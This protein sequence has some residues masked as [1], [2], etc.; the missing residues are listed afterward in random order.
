MLTTTPHLNHNAIQEND[1]RRSVYILHTENSRVLRLAWRT[2]GEE[3]EEVVLR[4][5]GILCDKHLPPI[6][7]SDV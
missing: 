4:I 3:V 6:Q 2:E 5:Q 1:Q 7:Q